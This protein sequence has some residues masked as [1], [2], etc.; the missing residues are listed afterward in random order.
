MVRTQLG[1]VL[2][3]FGL[4][5]A[6]DVFLNLSVTSHP[7]QNCAVEFKP[8]EEHEVWRGRLF[9]GRH[10]Q[11]ITRADFRLPPEADLM[12][13]ALDIRLRNPIERDFAFEGICGSTGAEPWRFHFRCDQ[14]R[15]IEAFD[16]FA[17]TAPDAP[18]A[19]SLG[20]RFSKI[21]YEGIPG[22]TPDQTAP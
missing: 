17:R 13:L 21:F 16:Q 9:L 7:G 11:I 2:R 22:G 12:L 8:S 6:Q 3:N 5:I 10:M 18:D 20:R 4:G 19:P 15:I 1:I 14:E